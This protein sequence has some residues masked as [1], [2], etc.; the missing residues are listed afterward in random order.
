MLRGEASYASPMA[1]LEPLTA[2]EEAFWRAL[3]RIV[4]TLPRHLHNDMV[5]A[6]GLSSSEYTVIMNLSEAPNRQLRMADLANATGLSPSRTTRVV[7]D[8]Q[9]RGLVTRRTSSAD[10]RSNLAALTAQGLTKLRS[11]WP[12]HLSSVRSRVLDH[13][14]PRTLAKVAQALGAVAAEL[15]NDRA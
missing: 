2:T 15:E 1:D 7:D 11:A 8:L 3:M 9:K 13:V 14:D 12:S 5:R 4:L 6:T 10:A